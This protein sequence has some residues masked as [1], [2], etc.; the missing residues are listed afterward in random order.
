MRVVISG[1]SGLV[2]SALT[3]RLTA[4]GHDVIRLV[5]RAEER[6][7]DAALWNPS[8]GEID[9]EA[10]EGAD[11]VVHLAGENISSGRWS[12]DRKKRIRDSRVDGTKLISETIASLTHRPRVLVSAS[13]IG[14]YGDRGDEVMTERSTP[15]EGFLPEVAIGWEA[16]TAAAA[17]AGT[18]VVLFRTGVVLSAA[19]GALAKML[20]LFRLGLGGRLGHGRQFMSWISLDDLLRAVFFLI[21][22]ETLSGPVNAVAPGAV[23]NAEF[24]RVLAKV[25]RRPAV[26]PAPALALKAAMGEMAEELLLSSTRVV[27]E[28]LLDAGFEF[29]HPDLES[30]LHSILS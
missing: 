24:T 3:A 18:R 8:K 4:E 25:L 27:P 6:A 21:E 10:H 29:A 13:A 1:A 7:A 5:R 30:A 19:G 12:P 20:P 9:R 26:F 28:R 17:G 11:V 2:G 16:A 14:F 15:G 23:T 22:T